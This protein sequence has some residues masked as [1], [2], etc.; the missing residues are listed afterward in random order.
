MSAQQLLDNLGDYL[1]EL[2]RRS[3]QQFE[4]WKESDD[5]LLDYLGDL[6]RRII[7]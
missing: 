5:D 4:L 7:S 3:A 2:S 1:G 6:S